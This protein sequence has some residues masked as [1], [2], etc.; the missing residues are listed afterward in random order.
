MTDHEYVE[1]YVD[2][3]DTQI[4]LERRRDM[5]KRGLLKLSPSTRPSHYVKTNRFWRL[6]Q[7]LELI[8]NKRTLTL[9][10]DEKTYE[11]IERAAKKADVSINKFIVDCLE[12]D[13]N[14]VKE[15]S[16]ARREVENGR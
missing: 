13:M 1:E 15:L 12:H 6:A 16:Q 11:I 10:L 9:T 2:Q 14:V 4:P 3:K 5:L 7:E 8:G